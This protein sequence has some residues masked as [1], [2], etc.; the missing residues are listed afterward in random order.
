MTEF[1]STGRPLRLY[2]EH[3]LGGDVR[4]LQSIGLYSMGSILTHREPKWAYWEVIPI[5]LV[6]PGLCFGVV[7]NINNIIRLL[8]TDHMMTIEFAATT[9]TAVLSTFKGCRLFVHRR[10]FYFL[11]KTCHIH[12]NVQVSRNTLTQSIVEIARLARLFRIYYGTVVIIA[13]SAFVVQPLGAYILNPPSRSNESIVF[14]KTIY[15]ARYPFTLNS[16]RAFFICLALETIGMYFMMLHW[17]ATDG[18]FTQFTT[19]LSLH[20]QILSNQIRRICPSTTISPSNSTTVSKRLKALIEEYIELFKYV[21]S[22]EKLYNPIIFATV[23]VNAIILCT[24][25]YSIQYNSAK[26]NWEDVEKNLL[27]ALGVSLQTLMF[28]TCA[29]R[30]NNEAIR[31]AGV[32]QAA[33]DCPWTAFSSPIKCSILMMMTLTQREYVY[34]AYGFIHLNMPQVTTIFTAAMRYFTLLR[35]IT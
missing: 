32:H 35:S 29:E 34:S 8:K 6:I 14:T 16:S 13:F 2:F 25:L 20:F 27:H 21:R 26:N 4:I 1:D 15:P 23:L 19:H 7:C 12:W 22:L 28:C 3:L 5:A 31:I 33:Y 18:L 11:I 30:L 10:E 17:I 9:L 24:C